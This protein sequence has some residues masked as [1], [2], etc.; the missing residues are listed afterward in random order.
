MGYNTPPGRV[1]RL[2]Y[3][4]STTPSDLGPLSV[5]D[6]SEMTKFALYGPGDPAQDLAVAATVQF[7]V[8]GA[9]NEQNPALAP[10]GLTV[11]LA[12]GGWITED[13]STILTVPIPD[14]AR[15][16]TVVGE[17]LTLGLAAAPWVQVALN[18]GDTGTLFLVCHA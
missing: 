8:F 9:P 10:V 11:G 3:E 18:A 13:G 17:A 2:V 12:G 5:V 1:Y 16:T 6:I 4:A 15:S 14:L 7:Q